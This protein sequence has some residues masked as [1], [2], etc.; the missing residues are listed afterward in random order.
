FLMSETID[1]I[2]SS[3]FYIMINLVDIYTSLVGQEHREKFGQFFTNREVAD[4]MVKWVLSGNDRALY[5]PAFGLGV[6][7]DAALANKFQGEFK[8]TEI[9]SQILSFFF[10]QENSGAIDVK[11]A[12]YLSIWGETYS[13]IICNPPYM[14]FQKFHGRKQVFADFEKH[15]NIK[16]SG[17][18]NIASAFLVKSI[19][20]L[21]QGGR[22][23]YI[24]PLEF[25]NTGYGTII[26]RQLIAEGNLHAIVKI[27]CEKDVFPDVTTSV[28][29][30][31]FEKNKT[32]NPIKF[33]VVRNLANIKNVLRDTPSTSLDVTQISP[34]QKWLRFF[35]YEKL[36]INSQKLNPISMYGAFSRGIATGANE[37]FVLNN[38]KISLTG[39]LPEEFVPCI[40]KSSQIKTAIFT[41]SDFQRL[42]D[43]NESV[44]LL[45]INGSPSPG[46]QDYL[47]QG[48]KF[49]F[50][51]RYLTKT[52]KP[53]YAIEKRTPAPLLFGV[54]SRE[55]FKVIR[56]YSNTRNLTCYHGFQPNL[57]GINY[58]DH[59]FLY[60]LSSTGRYILTQ[61]MRKY[62]DALDKFEPNDL[63]NAL[64]PNIDFFPQIKNID[65]EVDYVREYGSIS[66]NLED[67]FST[68]IDAPA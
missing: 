63:N 51:H 66:E 1:F 55:G 12:D 44:F 18:T 53:W 25:L 6:F 58:I 56:N 62:G 37:F 22:L 29:I 11:N 24:M 16:L 45:N 15:L 4:F 46:A 10:Q 33:F 21:S 57:F 50:H 67:I 48:E 17:Y 3:I 13:G 32:P 19:N 68:L 20:E 47:K 34:D 31:L 8:G 9:D 42:A 43:A 28:G 36:T 23:A 27:E 38:E 14:R 7:Y 35:E 49:G 30:I 65:R 64:C 39:L 59:L 26:K 2:P 40:T 41:D 52:R 5:D 60:F 61:N 54:F